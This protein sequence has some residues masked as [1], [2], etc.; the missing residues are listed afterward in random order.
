MTVFG[1][2]MFP[3]VCTDIS[4]I[5]QQINRNVFYYPILKKCLENAQLNKYVADV[6]M[7]M[8]VTR[9]GFYAVNEFMDYA[10][11]DSS[12]TSLATVRIY[13]LHNEKFQ[14]LYLG[15][16][17]LSADQAVNDYLNSEIE[18]IV[19]CN[20]SFAEEIYNSLVN[21]GINKKDVL[22]IDALIYGV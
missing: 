22:T 18:K 10:L 11:R 7:S 9:V 5:K 14:G 3:E 16:K 1:E 12:I 15:K 17:V 6:F 20:L 19:I 4:D 13:D 2:R 8:G 21:K